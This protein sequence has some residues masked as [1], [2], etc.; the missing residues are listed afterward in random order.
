MARADMLRMIMSKGKSA[1]SFNWNALTAPPMLALLSPYDIKLLDDIARDPRYSGK[2]QQ[3]RDIIDNILGARKFVRFASGTNRVV[4]KF[5]EDQSFLLKVA[6]S[7]AGLNDSPYEYINQYKI[8]PFV[9]KCFEVSDKGTLGTFERVQNINSREQFISIAQD[10]FGI[11]DDVI[12]GKYIMADIGTNFFMNWG[13]RDGFGPVILDYPLL[14]EVDGNKLFC[15]EI[16]QFGQHCGGQIDYDPGY[17]FLYCRKCGKQ[18]FASKLAKGGYGDNIKIVSRR[19]NTK[20]EITCM[21]GDQVLGTKNSVNSASSYI[22]QVRASKKEKGA[23]EI[24]AGIEGN[25]TLNQN[26][27]K[28]VVVP[29]APEMKSEEEQKSVLEAPEA[30]PVKEETKSTKRAS[31]KKKDPESKETKK[32]ETKT[33]SKLKSNMEMNMEEPEEEKKPKEKLKITGRSKKDPRKLSDDNE[34]N[35]Y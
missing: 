26:E 25:I 9:S 4:Y 29:T 8:A 19:E 34:M 20:M 12:I 32:K 14:Y 3:K 13:I 18:Y 22:Q 11:L 10:V 7:K 31:T 33:K 2:L 17:N 27:E 1:L 21:V 35:K 23:M 24:Y 6:I 30:T 28:K 15:N 16:D 5:L